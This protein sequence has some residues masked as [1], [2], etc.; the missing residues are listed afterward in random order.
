MIKRETKSAKNNTWHIVNAV[1]ILAISI[2]WLCLNQRGLL[3]F[4]K[5]LKDDLVFRQLYIIMIPIWQIR[6]LRFLSDILAQ[7]DSGWK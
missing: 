2:I 4:E 6:K 5:T 1:R 3:E 7:D